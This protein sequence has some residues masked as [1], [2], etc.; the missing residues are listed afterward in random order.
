MDPS[1]ARKTWR[2]L[3]PYHGLVYFAPQCTAAYEAIGVLGRDGYFASRSA[4]MGAVAPAVVKATF[5]N[6]HPRLIDHAIPAVW[7]VASPA[8]V[9]AAR[10]SGVDAALRAAAGDALVDDAG[11]ARAAALARTA[12]E[13][14]TCDG[15]PLALAHQVLPWP[16]V[17]HLDLWHAI[18]VLREHRGDGHVSCLVAEG[19]GGCEALVL[20]AASGE[21]PAAVLQASRAWSDDEWATAVAGLAERGL[22]AADGSF[23]DAGRALR[24]SVEDRTDALAVQPWAAIGADACDELR[25]LVRPW[26][27]AIGASGSFGFGG[28]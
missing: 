10:L 25:G 1:V 15:R 11:V 4:P 3:E 8:D 27:K 5:L 28:G 21:V 14:A 19:I 7:S 20:H 2:T 12:A 23:T 26:S 13:A 22:V 18:S 17:P 16:D 24:Q 9:L 6:F